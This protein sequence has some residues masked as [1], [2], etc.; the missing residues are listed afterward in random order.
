MIT[1]YHNAVIFRG[2]SQFSVLAHSIGFFFRGSVFHDGITR[3]LLEIMSVRFL[4]NYSAAPIHSHKTEYSQRIVD[5]DLSDTQFEHGLC[6]LQGRGVP[7]DLVGA[8]RYFKLAADQGICEAQFQ[9][10]LC[11]SEK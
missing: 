2:L 10:G 4:G 3:T 6:L 11:L 1:P 5:Q 9:Y 7:I 8:V